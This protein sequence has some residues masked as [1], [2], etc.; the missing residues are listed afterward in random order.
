MNVLVYSDEEQI[1]IAAGNYMCGQVLQKPDSVLGLATGS[2]PL[3]PYKQM[4]EL[5]RK[6]VIDFSRVTTFNLDEYVNL[7]INDKNS[8]HTFMRENLFDK[9]NIPPENINFLDGNAEDLQLECDSYEKRIKAAGGIDIQLLG[10]GSNGHIAFNEPSDCFQRWSHVVELKESTV[11]DNS[12]FFNSL[13]EVPTKAVTMGI[14][15]IMQAKKILII[16]IGK[17]KAHAIKQVINGNVTP[18]CPASVLQ[19]HTD[20]TLMLDKDAASLINV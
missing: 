19:F 1:G 7:D 11:K 10:I 12:R 15:S 17:K 8:Y 3:K 5:Y 14:G 2:T 18:M 20:V 13:D 4:T 9:I 16:A 6:G